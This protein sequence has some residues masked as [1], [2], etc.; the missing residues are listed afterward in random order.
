MTE[1]KVCPHCGIEFTPINP[2]QVYCTPAH[3]KAAADKRRYAAHAES[4]RTANAQRQQAQR[5][6][7]ARLRAAAQ[8][9]KSAKND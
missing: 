6:E 3:Q 4:I 8:E 1:N 9:V 5:D 7:L 2:R